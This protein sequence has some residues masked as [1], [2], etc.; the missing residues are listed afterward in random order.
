MPNAD[1]VVNARRVVF[2]RQAVAW[3]VALAL[4]LGLP[5]L[6]GHRGTH[7][8]LSL[9]LPG[10]GLWGPH[11]VWGVV[12]LVASTAAAV[13]W[14][15]WGADWLVVVCALT[16][17]VLSSRWGTD[18]AAALANHL[19]S[20]SMAHEFPLVVL[21][22]GALGAV[23]RVLVRVPGV[24]RGFRSAHLMTRVRCAALGPSEAAS[25]TLLDGAPLRDR[26]RRIGVVARARVHNDA[27]AR[28]HAGVR[29]ARVLAGL[30][31]GRAH[32]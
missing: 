8:A 22:V 10:S 1:T 9:L 18:Q 27:F 24:R 14:F 31:I 28:D 26:C 17:A 16:A 4:V 12:L 7:A 29:A 11:T 23:R 21:V 32:V 6:F 19:R 13:L 3:V 2:R 15:R 5:A 20:T 30:E 25:V